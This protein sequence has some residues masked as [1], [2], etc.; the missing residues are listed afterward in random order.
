MLS[1]F[2]G[3]RH[4]PEVVGV[5]CVIGDHSRACAPSDPAMLCE[6]NLAVDPMPSRRIPLLASRRHQTINN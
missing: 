6:R 4:P 1:F 2:L 3:I 5:I